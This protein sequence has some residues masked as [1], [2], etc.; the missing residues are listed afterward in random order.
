MSGSKRKEFSRRVSILFGNFF[1]RSGF[2]NSWHEP[3]LLASPIAAL[4]PGLVEKK[5]AWIF[6]AVAIGSAVVGSVRALMVKASTL[7]VMTERDELR[8]QLNNLEG[9]DTERRALFVREVRQT[10]IDLCVKV[11]IKNGHSRASIYIHNGASFASFIRFSDNPIHEKVGRGFY[12]EDQGI[13]AIA[14][15]TG[16]DICTRLP[17][18][19][20]NF[21]QKLLEKYKIPLRV[22]KAFQMKSRSLV[23]IRIPDSINH[24]KAHIGVLVIEST[25]PLGVTSVHRDSVLASSP[26]G[27]LGMQLSA[28]RDFLPDISE[29]RERG[30]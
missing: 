4:F 26:W 11:S 8:E 29:A 20:P 21:S 14:W 16:E 22:S 1:S 24:T 3:L 10:L 18:T 2:K 23:A 12:P 15:Q 27:A 30:F 7:D 19:Q 28:S 13:I 17:S 25:Q 9:L 6:I 5:L